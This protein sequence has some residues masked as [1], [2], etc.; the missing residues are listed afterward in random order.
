MAVQREN[1]R[2]V[3]RGVRPVKFRLDN[4]DLDG[5]NPCSGGSPGSS[6]GEV[7]ARSHGDSGSGSGTETGQGRT[8]WPA[9]SYRE[10]KVRTS[11]DRMQQQQ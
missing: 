3:D 8:L 7:G 2:A 5:E 4:V 10:S 11:L 1:R 9:R 6:Q